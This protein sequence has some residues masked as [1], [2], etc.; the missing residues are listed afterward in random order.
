MGFVC[1][2]EPENVRMYF[3]LWDSSPEYRLLPTNNCKISTNKEK[4]HC[5]IVGINLYKLLPL[6]LRCLGVIT[7]IVDA[8]MTTTFASWH[9]N[10]FMEWQDN[11]DRVCW[12]F[13]PKLWL[14]L[15]VVLHLKPAKLDQN[16]WAYLF[17][18][19]FL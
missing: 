5:R 14:Q 7:Y 1:K 4:T 18:P 11:T 16:V 12:C 19:S 9:C 2:N 13:A 10:T 8:E 17:L 3:Y 6:I 15:S